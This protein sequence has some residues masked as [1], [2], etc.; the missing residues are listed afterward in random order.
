MRRQLQGIAVM[1]LSMIL[2]LGFNSIGVK[3]V[4]D[5]SLHWSRVFMIIGILGF[6]ISFRKGD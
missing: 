6:V 5:L 2:I 1:L 3:Y 4:F